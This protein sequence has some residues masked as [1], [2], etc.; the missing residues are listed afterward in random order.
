[1]LLTNPLLRPPL[2]AK[3]ER[4]V[5]H[6]LFKSKETT[7]TIIS[8][9][10]GPTVVPTYRIQLDVTWGDWCSQNTGRPQGAGS[11]AHKDNPVIVGNVLEGKELRTLVAEAEEEKV[12]LHLVKG[13]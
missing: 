12:G 13:A 1:M 2:Y 4:V 5:Y 6:C 7:G 9:P 3:G 10:I 11:Y 8:A